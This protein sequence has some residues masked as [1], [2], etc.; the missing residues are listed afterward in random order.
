[1]RNEDLEGTDRPNDQVLNYNIKSF[2]TDTAFL[3]KRAKK[4]RDIKSSGGSFDD[5]SDLE[6][7]IKYG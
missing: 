3:N 6:C 4:D 7:F 1:M 5:K 2:E